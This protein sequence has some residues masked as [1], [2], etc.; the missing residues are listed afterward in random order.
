MKLSQAAGMLAAV[1]FMATSFQPAGAYAETII[2]YADYSPNRGTRAEQVEWFLNEI[3]KQSEGRIKIDAQWGGALLP[4]KGMFDG[5][6][7]G[8]AG[9]GTVTAA[10]SPKEL[11]AYRVGD[12]PILNPNEVAEAM[13]LYDLA[14]TDDDMKKEFD[15]AG[16]VYVANY[17]VGPN[18]MICKGD[19]ITTLE[20]FKGKKV[21]YVGEYGKILGEFGAIPVVLALPE[22]YKALDSGLIDCSQTYGYVTLAYKLHEVANQFV[23]FDAG[24]I[25]SNGIFMNKDQFEALEPADQKMILELGRQMTERNA[26]AIRVG[27]QAAIKKMAEGIDG[28]VVNVTY[29]SNEERAKLSKAS[30]KYIQ[31]WIDEADKLG[32]DGAKL[33]QE[34]EAL[35]NKYTTAEK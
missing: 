17:T 3:E 14:T 33:A 34:Y 6:K 27:N 31:N 1:L 25:A 18:Q 10:Y 16:V 11:T 30:D 22:A 28:H 5:I 20:G 23:V 26:R 13:A 19:P 12:I 35:V 7:A 8:V 4:A 9:M 29:L 15:R 2:R 32:Y 21:R 24:T